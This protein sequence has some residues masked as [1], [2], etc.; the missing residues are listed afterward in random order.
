MALLEVRD[1][2]VEIA[3]KQIIKELNL[4]IEPGSVHAIMGP[5]GA[6]KSTLG[7]A[8]AGH[9]AYKVTK[10]DILLNGQSVLELEPEERSLA[11]VFFSLQHPIEIPGVP[12]S[13]FLKAAVNAHRKHAGKKEIDAIAFAKMLRQKAS[14]LI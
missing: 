10:G 13:A 4:V 3:E 6:G 9:H 14:H 12:I 1:L 5:N 11:G 7:Y 8:L 2:C